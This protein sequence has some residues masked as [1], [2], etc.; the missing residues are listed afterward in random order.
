[1][2]FSLLGGGLIFVCSFFAGLGFNLNSIEGKVKIVSD[3]TL[4]GRILL[5]AFLVEVFSI[6]ILYL[7]GSNINTVFQLMSKGYTNLSFA[8]NR[9]VV[10]FYIYTLLFL[11]LILGKTFSLLRKRN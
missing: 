9:I 11:G 7:S 5:I 8:N 6:V 1:M 3:H 4:T 2:I 10:G